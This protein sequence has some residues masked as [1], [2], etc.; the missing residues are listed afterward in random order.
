MEQLTVTSPAF[1][2]GGDIPRR[3]SGRG[4]DLSPPLVFHGL[5]DGAKALA[6]TLDD[7][8][9]PLFGVY[10]HW[11]MWNLPP[12]PALPEG[13]PAGQRLAQLGGAV[14]GV[15]YGRHRYRGP[16]PPLRARHRYVF[17]VYALD[18]PLDL[19]PAARKR[20]LLAAMEGHVLQTAELSGYFQNK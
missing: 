13:L 4:E 6:V 19:P 20:D 14:Q 16:K 3:H 17:T 11:L 7:A 5:S 10:C 8:S 1:S 12:L 15:G 9:H 2:E 18:G